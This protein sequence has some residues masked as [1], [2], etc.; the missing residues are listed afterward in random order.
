MHKQI[1]KA[2]PDNTARWKDQT[3][4]FRKRVVRCWNR[5]NR[6]LK[7][8]PLADGVVSC[9]NYG[10]H[11]VCKLVLPCVESLQRYAAAVYMGRY[12]VP[13]AVIL[14]VPSSAETCLLKRGGAGY[15]VRD[16]RGA[17]TPRKGVLFVPT[18]WPKCIVY[19]GGYILRRTHRWYFEL[20]MSALV[21]SS[22]SYVF[23]FETTEI[24]IRRSLSEVRFN[25]HC[26][27]RFSNSSETPRN[28]LC[29]HYRYLCAPLLG[30]T[31]KHSFEVRSSAVLLLGDVGAKNI[32]R[33]R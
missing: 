19:L 6:V 7:I 31:H 33:F 24:P 8:G 26:S 10:T 12:R 3:E 20:N 1:P 22:T 9:V 18:F 17:T 21:C 28:A 4:N 5:F 13:H 23:R 29:A 25:L 32:G 2:T 16:R 30:S 27:L 14:A 11:A 15:T